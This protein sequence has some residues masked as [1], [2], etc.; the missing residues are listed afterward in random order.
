[1][2]NTFSGQ[3]ANELEQKKKKEKLTVDKRNKNDKLST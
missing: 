3:S 1:M 2:Q